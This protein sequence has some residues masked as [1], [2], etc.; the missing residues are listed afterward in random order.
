MVIYCYFDGIY[1]S[2]CCF[3]LV[4]RFFW[5]CTTSQNNINRYSRKNRDTAF[6]VGGKTVNK[7]MSRNPTSCST[8]NPP[9]ISSPPPNIINTPMVPIVR[10]HPY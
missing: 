3:S 5:V 10:F 2:V 9:T 6:L 1:L 4:V 8:E 7:D